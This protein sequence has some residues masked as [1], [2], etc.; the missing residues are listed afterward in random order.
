MAR[1]LLRSRVK[2][3]EDDSLIKQL[4]DIA[5]DGDV[6]AIEGF[7]LEQR[8]DFERI[9]KGMLFVRTCLKLAYIL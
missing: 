9:F 8:T 7:A 3:N 6:E 1:Q 2:I 5:L 4:Q